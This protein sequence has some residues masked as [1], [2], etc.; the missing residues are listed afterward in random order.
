[1]TNDLD[2]FK[3]L[4]RHARSQ[5]VPSP[6]EIV[7][8]AFLE[9]GYGP[10]SLPPETVRSDFDRI[11]G[12]VFSKT[13]EVLER[14]EEPAYAAQAIEDLMALR[15]E[16]V[17]EAASTARQAGFAA[18]FRQLFRGWYPYLRVLFL[19]VS[20]S[21]KARGGRDFELQLRNLFDFMQVPY[22]KKKRTYR[23]DFIMPSERAFKRDPNRC[24]IISAKRTLRERWQEVVDELYNLRAP[25]VYLVTADDQI[26][27]DKVAEINRRNIY[28]VTWDDV[29]ERFFRRRARVIGYT[30]LANKVIAHFKQYWTV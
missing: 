25:N 7:K 3:R 8:E 12:E 28:L 6:D 9:V 27:A 5:H 26:S 10:G 20:Q 17:S 13:L 14:Y 2:D 30:A 23:A 18:A 11:L 22:E 21:R 1:M 15:P 24:L 4:V 19:S 16:D 29:K